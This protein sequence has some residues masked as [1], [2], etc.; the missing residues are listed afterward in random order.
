MIN[1]RKLI[2]DVNCGINN[3]LDEYADD[4]FYSFQDQTVIPGAIYLIGYDQVQ[5]TLAKLQNL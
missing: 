4:K 1:N 3:K 2:P 5:K